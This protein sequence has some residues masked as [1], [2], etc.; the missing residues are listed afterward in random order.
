MK[1]ITK[2]LTCL[3]LALRLPGL[4]AELASVNT[5]VMHAADKDK[6]G[7]LTLEEYKPLDV[8]AKHHGEEHFKAGDARQGSLPRLQRTH[9]HPS[10]ANLVR[11]PQRRH[12]R[13]FLRLDTNHDGNLDA[14]EYRRISRMGA[15]AG[16]HFKSADVDKNGSLTLPSSPSML[17]RKSKRLMS[18]LLE[19]TEPQNKPR[20]YPCHET[21]LRT[22]HRPAARTAGRA[23]CR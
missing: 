14:S 4:H 13:C 1:S 22:P 5:R 15:H 2:I 19:R 12:G 11:H 8:Q 21:H 6:D 23:A 16:Q 20:D 9:H 18:P 7:K 10:Q 3:L 17:R